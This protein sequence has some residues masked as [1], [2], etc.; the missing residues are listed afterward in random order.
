MRYIPIPVDRFPDV[1]IH[2]RYT[3]FPDEP[4]NKSLDLCG[5]GEAHTELE[6]HSWSTMEQGFSVMALDDENEVN[7]SLNKLYLYNEI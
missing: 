3:F 1:I 5:V 2:L 7:I 4:L 6:L